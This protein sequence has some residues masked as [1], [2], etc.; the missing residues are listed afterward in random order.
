MWPGGTGVHEPQAVCPLPCRFVRIRP[1]RNEGRY[2]H[3]D[4]RPNLFGGTTLV[5]EWGRLG[6]FGARHLAFFDDYDGALRVLNAI[7]GM[8]IRRGYRRLTPD[9]LAD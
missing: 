5:R 7:A 8:K 4:I 6:R 2:Y 3:L 9:P 1:E